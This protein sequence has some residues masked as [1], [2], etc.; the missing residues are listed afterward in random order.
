MFGEEKDLTIEVSF[1]GPTRTKDPLWGNKYVGGNKGVVTGYY[2]SI[3]LAVKGI[4]KANQT[5]PVGIFF[6]ANPVKKDIRSRSYNRFQPNIQRTKDNE[7][8]VLKWL[9]IDFDP[10][11][12]SG[13]SSTNAEHDLAI[14]HAQFVHKSICAKGCTPSLI[15]DSGNGAHIII[16]LPDLPNT[17]ENVELLKNFLKSMNSF[18]LIRKDDITIEIDEKVFNP[19]RL[20]KAAGTDVRKGDSTP[21]RPHR[22][23]RIISQ[24]EKATPVSV[25]FLEKIAS[26]SVKEEEEKRLKIEANKKNGFRT[27]I[28]STVDK[29]INVE[30]Y[31]KHYS[32]SLKSTKE[33]GSSTFYV[34]N[35]CVFDSSH[36]GG[37]AAVVQDDKGT[38]YYQCFHDSC[39]DKK[40]SDARYVISG[41]DKL[42][43]F[44]PGFI[45]HNNKRGTA[46]TG[47]VPNSG[48]TSTKAQTRSAL[49]TSP[50]A[51]D[52]L[53]EEKIK[54]LNAEHAVVKLN[55]MTV[56]MN[57]VIDPIFDRPA[58]NFSSAK[59]LHLYYCNQL[60]NV[61]AGNGKTTAI[62][63]SN[64][65]LKHPKRRQYEGVTFDPSSDGDKNPMLYNLYNGLALKPKQGNWTLYYDHLLNVICGKNEEYCKYLI[66]WIAQMLQF[67]ANKPGVAVVLRGSKG[68]GKGT[69]MQP[70]EMIFGQHYLHITDQ[71]KLTGKFNQ[72]M[73]DCLLAFC[74]EGFW[75]GDKRAEGV[76]K[77]LI[78][79]PTILLEPKGKDPFTV[80]NH[81]HL[82]IAT[83]EQW[84]V[85]AS[86]DDRR[87][88]VLDVS[89][90]YAQNVQYFKALT[91]EIENGGAEAF[92]YDM[93]HYDL[94]KNAV[95]LR[96]PPKTRG[97]E[98]QAEYSS[99]RTTGFW[100][101]CLKLGYQIEKE[102]AW[103]RVIE[104]KEAFHKEYQNYCDGVGEK[105]KATLIGFMMKIKQ[106]CPSLNTRYLMPSLMK[107]VRICALKFPTL[108]QARAE[109]DAAMNTSLDWAEYDA[110]EEDYSVSP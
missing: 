42:T 25:E 99:D 20:I 109:F 14:S 102:G 45:Q 57:N 48:A 70:L 15:V 87:W 98:D 35:N 18:Y 50:E 103:E 82:I 89:K 28:P 23:S 31:L 106:M 65:W 38:L 10:Q 8:D 97:M 58:V 91:N 77:G 107:G 72:H 13:I 108:K 63:I 92:L 9:L 69:F 6:V 3:D 81:V 67:P 76:I 93:L 21:D 27:P 79:E 1:F 39:K 24:P 105:Y 80:K 53:I 110:E 71:T 32:V 4:E 83:N 16:R 56:I 26:I 30:D 62:S 34:L 37:E 64:I 85:P 88:F 74:D 44:M 100:V 2:D 68:A 19:A 78:T 104:S 73:K 46:T 94:K 54:E 11:R 95:E 43:P 17:P 84:A 36:S 60:Y 75:A 33:N 49:D 12:P 55:G 96:K 66:A 52:D 90:D 29:K 59:D 47:S 86:Y 22:R 5:S 101:Q 41:T 51:D 40:W 7:V 61:P